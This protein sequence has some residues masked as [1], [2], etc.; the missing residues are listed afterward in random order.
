MKNTIKA[1]ILGMLLISAPL[2]A[3]DSVK[4][5]AIVKKDE[6]KKKK[7]K[8]D[9]DKLADH[10]IKKNDINREF[11]LTLRNGMTDYVTLLFIAL[12][13][14]NNKKLTEKLLVNG[15]DKNYVSDLGYT[16]Y[17][18]AKMGGRDDLAELVKPSIFTR[19]GQTI[20]TK[21][22]EYSHTVSAWYELF[23]TTVFLLGANIDQRVKY[24]EEENKQFNQKQQK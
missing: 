12:G 18:Y 21:L 4:R 5:S 15:A 1:I 8:P 16:A 3:N 10:L 23:E 13:D 19:V 17:D 2:S 9:L 24:V 11:K 14:D 6:D 7:K 22:T 20:R